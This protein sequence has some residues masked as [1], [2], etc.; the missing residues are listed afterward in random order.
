MLAV[1][2]RRLEAATGLAAADYDLSLRIYGY[3][4]VT[5]TR[6]PPGTQAPTELGVMF[7]ATAATQQ[8]ATR[9]AKTCNPWFFHFPLDKG[10]EPPSYAFPF[11]WAEIER[12]QVYAFHHNHVVAVDDP[13]ELTR[14]A[15]ADYAPATRKKVAH[16]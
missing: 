1:L 3:N 12:R 14:L 16:A 4:G 9:I 6:P 13:P 10:V 8:M 7:V 2:H 11:S 5:D 15:W